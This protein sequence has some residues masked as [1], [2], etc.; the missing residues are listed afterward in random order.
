MFSGDQQVTWNH[1][2]QAAACAWSPS[3]EFV[4]TTSTLGM[5][6]LRLRRRPST[7]LTISSHGRFL[8]ELRFSPDGSRMAVGGVDGTIDLWDT[9]GLLELSSREPDALESSESAGIASNVEQATQDP[10]DTEGAPPSAHDRNDGADVSLPSSVRPVLIRSI[11]AYPSEERVGVDAL[12]FSTDGTKLASYS[13]TSGGV[14][15][16]WD[17]SR[18]K[19][20]YEVAEFGEDLFSG[21]LGLTFENSDQGIEVA[22]VDSQYLDVVSGEIRVGDRIIAFA[23]D[24]HGELNDFSELEEIELG[25]LLR[26]P[27][28]SVVQLTVER[29]NDRRQVTLRRAKKEDPRSMRLCFSPD[30]TTAAIAG[31]KHGTS[32]INLATE[33]T[34]RFPASLS[35]SVAISRGNLLATDALTEVLVWD[36]GKDLEHA[37][38]DARVSVDPIPTNSLAGSLAFSPDGKF[39]AIGTGYAYDPGRK[40]SDLKVWRVS[41]LKEVGGAPLFKHDR[42]LSDITFTPDSAHLI[43]TCHDG[44]AR[45]WNT[46]SWELMDRQFV[47]RKWLTSH[48]SFFGRQDAGHRLAGRIRSSSGTSL[49]GKKLR[50]LSGPSSWVLDF[51]P[52]G[53]TLVSGSSNHNVILWDVATGMQLR[54]FHAHTNAVM[55]AAFSPDG[56]TLATAGNEGVLRLWEAASFEEIESSPPTLEAMF[57]LGTLRISEDRYEEAE[58]IFVTLLKLQDETSAAWA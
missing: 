32:T 11:K 19:G 5:V 30:G 44:I 49:S 48:R 40:R 12:V 20:T 53:K 24:T 9:S 2:G 57:R 15:Q 51:S 23:D 27:L 3:G 8:T 34:Q 46:E 45:V 42:V 28:R 4:V 22:S 16:L 25:V 21:R 36:L 10:R 13:R 29:E 43:A 38:L 35:N 37:R 26:G 47:A 18:V 7:K 14:S 41:D 52:D 31:Q 6:H 1:R 58:R 55:G 56:N 33:R 50:V 17:V 54:T 39:L